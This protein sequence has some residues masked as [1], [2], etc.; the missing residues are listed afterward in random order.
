MCSLAAALPPEPIVDE[1][2]GWVAVEAAPRR[3]FQFCFSRRNLKMKRFICILAVLMLASPAWAAKKLTVQQ[4][5]DLLVS[6]QNDRKTDVET[7]TE[8][9]QIELTEELTRAAMNKTISLTPGK[10]SIEQIY[11]LEARSATLPPPASDLPATA[12]PDAAAQKAILDKAVTYTAKYNSQ[13]PPL[14]ATKTTLRFQDNMEAID[15]CSGMSGCAQGVASASSFSKAASFIHFINSV[16][17]QVASEHGIEKKPSSPDKTPWGANGMIVLQEPDPS[18]GI[19]LQ[20]AQSAQRLQWL[21][22]ELVNGKPVAVFSFKVPIADSQFPVDI[23]CFPRSVQVG[24]ANFY[25]GFNAAQVAGQEAASGGGGGVVGNF[26]TNTNYKLHFNAKV[27]FH[28]E[29]FVDPATGIVLRLITQADFKAS[30]NVQQEDTRIDYGPVMVNA[31]AMILPV[32][33]VINT[34][35]APNGD[36]GSGTFTTRR[37]LFT[38]EYKNYQLAAH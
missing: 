9:K 36:S 5:N 3:L 33:T 37:T 29:I 28:G 19:V 24:V 38:S 14:T 1:E 20:G 15:A 11:V 25:N 32:R 27:P 26:Q 2:Q 31:K 23:C 22:W 10:F 30:D 18:L 35:V 34:V 16:E 6:F 12:A 17:T 4:L 7:A 8:L 21:R 13:L